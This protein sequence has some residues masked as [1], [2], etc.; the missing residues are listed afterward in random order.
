MADTYNSPGVNIETVRQLKQAGSVKNLDNIYSDIVAL[1]IEQVTALCPT[2]EITEAEIDET[3][4]DVL[5]T[6]PLI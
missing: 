5:K 2:L 4:N 6:Y 1:I 3:L